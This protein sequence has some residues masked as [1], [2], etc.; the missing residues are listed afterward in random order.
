[1]KEARKSPNH[2]RKNRDSN[3]QHPL[4]TS[5]KNPP[6]EQP[7]LSFCFFYFL[8][9]SMSTPA[10][11]SPRRLSA[12]RD[13]AWQRRDACRLL[14]LLSLLPPR[15]PRSFGSHLPKEGFDETWIFLQD[16]RVRLGSRCRSVADIKQRQES[17]RV[18]LQV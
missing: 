4:R 6:T 9:S 7:T 13:F 1:M 2:I 17:Y 18:D 5:K 12:L 10:V 3:M 8:F 16:T 11:P 14:G 15:L